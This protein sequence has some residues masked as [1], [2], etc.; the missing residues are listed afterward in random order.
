MCCSASDSKGRLQRS[1]VPADS[2]ALRT[3]EMPTANAA[4]GPSGGV[5]VAQ[6]P[7]GAASRGPAGPGSPTPTPLP[8]RRPAL[9][10]DLSRLGR[11]G[12]T[13]ST[14]AAASVAAR[15]AAEATWPTADWLQLAA[16]RAYAGFARSPAFTARGAAPM[17]AR[18][19]CGMH[20]DAARAPA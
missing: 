13:P 11:A 18:R 8:A 1:T 14:G 15:S 3:A 12:E 17:S 4:P 20:T 10:L 9:S 7:R 5:S 6:T 19:R 16:G 2:S